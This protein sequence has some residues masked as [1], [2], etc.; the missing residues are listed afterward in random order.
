MVEQ[1]FTY[2]NDNWLML[3]KYGVAGLVV[4][5]LIVLVFKGVNGRWRWSREKY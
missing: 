4:A 1:L 5:F 3:L 2:I